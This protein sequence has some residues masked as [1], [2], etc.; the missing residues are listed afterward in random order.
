MI[1]KL[2]KYQLNHYFNELEK[3][4]PEYTLILKLAYIYG[5]NTSEILQLKPENIGEITITIKQTSITQKYPISPELKKQ[6][7]EY[8]KP[9]QEYIFQKIHDEEKPLIILNEFMRKT[10]RRIKREYTIKIPQLTCRDF[11]RLRGQHL[12]LDGA[13]INLV[14]HLYGNT[15]TRITRKF[16]QIEELL[17]EA[18]R[19]TS[20]NDIIENYTDLNLYY[21]NQLNNNYQLYHISGP[22]KHG[23]N[24]N[25]EIN[26]NTKRINLE[27]HDVKIDQLLNDEIIE[28]LL[29]LKVGEYKIINKLRIT[30]TL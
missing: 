30:R 27:K 11:K 1:P 13:T 8:I 3:E 21:D 6:I 29:K 28:Q 25:I 18:G 19:P 12:I 20:I 10:N 17:Q 24:N 26:N 23:Y 5:K 16:L 22:Q 7:T 9:E 4:N 2:N 15:N 14:R